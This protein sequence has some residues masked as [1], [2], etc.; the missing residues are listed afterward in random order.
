LYRPATIK[1]IQYVKTKYNIPDNYLLHVGRIDKKKN[2]PTLVEAFAQVKSQERKFVN[3]KLVIVGGVYY[4]SQDDTLIPTIKRL[5]LNKDV[6]FTGNISDEDLPAIYSCSRAFVY[7]SLHEGFGL[8][9]VEAIACGTPVI[10]HKSGGVEE[11]VGSAAIL[12][13]II[14]KESLSDSIIQV[15]NDDNLRKSMVE[16]GLE[17]AR[18]YNQESIANKTLDLYLSLNVS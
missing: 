17:Q 9:A 8:V 10:A 13:D 5:N 18:K 15:L 11:A 16:A 4:K 1:Q 6:I 7:P 2:L 12:L 14:D 3:L